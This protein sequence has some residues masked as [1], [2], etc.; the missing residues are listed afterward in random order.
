MKPVIL[1]SLAALAVPAIVAAQ[2]PSPAT[3]PG[4]GFTTAYVTTFDGTT[5]KTAAVTIR[6]STCPVYMQAKQGSGS[7]LVMV[8]KSGPDDGQSAPSSKPGQRIHL[9]LGRMPGA[10]FGDPQQITGAMVTAKGLSARD[11]LEPALDLLSNRPS[12]IR[13]TMNV[14]FSTEKDGTISADVILPGFTSV[15][16]IRLDSVDLKDGSTWTLPDLKACVVTP[17]P[18]ML[19]ATQ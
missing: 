10:H 3:A 7:G 5:S 15:S 11:H 19:V 8:R 18:L 1:L 2:S 9:I 12:D 17:D 4:A 13:R 6:V 16:S 14:I